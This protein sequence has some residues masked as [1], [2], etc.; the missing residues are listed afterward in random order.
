MFQSLYMLLFILLTKKVQSKNLSSI[1]EI[2]EIYQSLSERNLDS[3]A[4][5][6][7][8]AQNNPLHLVLFQASTVLHIHQ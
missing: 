6:T 4:L 8:K 5:T 2:A 3:E 1:E 7:K